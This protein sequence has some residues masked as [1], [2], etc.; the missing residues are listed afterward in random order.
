MFV[1]ALTVTPHPEATFDRVW[2]KP[3]EVATLVTDAFR[4]IARDGASLIE[5]QT[6]LQKGLA[7]IAAAAPEH[8]ATLEA[9]ARDAMRRARTSLDKADHRDLRA[10]VRGLW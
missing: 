1:R 10:T 7:S 3:P 8:H 6:R 9:A 4:P 2:I 5:V